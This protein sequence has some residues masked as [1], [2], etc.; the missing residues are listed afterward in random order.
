MAKGPRHCKH[1]SGEENARHSKRST[2]TCYYVN[3]HPKVVHGRPTKQC[4]V[5][6]Q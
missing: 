2:C 6:A 1:R 3:R 4:T 5:A